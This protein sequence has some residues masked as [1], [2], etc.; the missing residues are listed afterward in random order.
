[1]PT[2]VINFGQDDKIQSPYLYVQTAGS[3]ASD[4]STSGVHLRWTLRNAIE[5]HLPKGNLAALNAPYYSTAGFNKAN[6][7]VKIYRVPYSIKYQASIKFQ[8]DVPDRLTEAPATTRAWEFDKTINAITGQ[9]VLTTLILRF[10]DSAQYDTIRSGIDP[11]IN[12]WDFIKTYTGV[13]EIEAKNKLSFAVT[14]H[15]QP[16]DP[17]NNPSGLLRTE[18]IS[19]PDTDEA[20]LFISCRK[21]FDDVFVPST[22]G[23]SL[24]VLNNTAFLAPDNCNEHKVMIENIKY[25]RFDYKNFSP[26]EIYVETYE[27]FFIGAN[28]N[29]TVQWQPLGDFS[30]SIDDTEVLNRLDN[31]DFGVDANW[32]KY[33][34]RNSPQ[35]GAA[36]VKTQNYIDRWTGDKG[37]KYG[38]ETYLEASRSASN[39]EAIVVTSLDTSGETYNP[40]NDAQFDI[41]YL[42]MLQ[43]VSM[44]FHN[45]RM[46]GLGHIDTNVT[47]AE[48]F[49]YLSVYDTIVPLE[50]DAP[51]AVKHFYMALP[52][53]RADSR[54]PET[55]V[56]KNLQYGLEVPSFPKPLRLT[57]ALGYIPY[58]NKR[59]ISLFRESTITDEEYSEIFFVS[60]VEFCTQNI[61]D[62]VF[63]GIEYRLS[64]ESSWRFP[65]LLGQPDIVEFT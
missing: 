40:A 57:D 26:G 21:H 52:T 23:P 42:E 3:D 55:P 62:T 12:P 8:E 38:V 30:L 9:T 45:A 35:T 18:A 39:P 46:M 60:N 13:L 61:T 49:I 10:K 24:P 1:M 44:D 64:S 58:E 16:N 59:Y 43:M 19:L 22:S 5:T 48:K 50:N 2:S 31:V 41:N 53:G 28:I 4:G 27:D 51:S 6:D 15:T 29:Q 11:N 17:L 37:L 56:L 36:T 14:F 33:N 20:G 25:V 65:E 34:E 47:G 63:V 32:P 7:F 54:L